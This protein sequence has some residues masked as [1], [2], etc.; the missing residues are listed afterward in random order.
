MD[1]TRIYVGWDCHDQRA[2]DVCLFSIQRHA[3][4]LVEI[5]SLKP[6]A[7][8]ALCGP[9]PD[10]Q[11]AAR[12]RARFLVPSL[13]DF[14][15]WA[16]FVS[17]DMLFQADIYDLW[18]LRDERYAVMGVAA[19]TGAEP[20]S[21]LRSSLLLW[22]C[23]HSANRGLTAKTIAATDPSR[24]ER[25]AWLPKSAVGA[26]PPAWCWREGASDPDLAP[27]A[28]EFAPEKPWTGAAEICRYADRWKDEAVRIF[29]VL[30]LDAWGRAARA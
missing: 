7:V 15:G 21:I 4:D 14:T 10:P 20:D 25:F 16:A 1:H 17:S 5:V 22:N 27:K 23:G 29:G 30:A 18:R 11:G 26:L 3:S 8:T 6:K 24:L 28:I 12:A 2:L 19:E 9:A 13:N